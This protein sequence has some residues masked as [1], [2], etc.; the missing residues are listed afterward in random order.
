MAY[1][2]PEK[3]REYFRKWRAA[4]R[5]KC[6]LRR[7]AVLA[8]PAAQH[9]LDALREESLRERFPDEIVSAHLEAEQFVEFLV[10]RVW[11]T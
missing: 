8:A 9:G 1:K 10:L 5:E 7:R 11:E 2:D 6:L 4:N 3:R